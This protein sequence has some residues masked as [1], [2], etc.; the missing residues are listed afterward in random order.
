M[1]DRDSKIREMK[2]SLEWNFVKSSQMLKSIKLVSKISWLPNFEN[3]TFLFNLEM[4][5]IVTSIYSINFT[6]H[7]IESL[8]YP[9]FFC[10]AFPVSVVNVMFCWS[11]ICS[12]NS[13]VFRIDII[14][15]ISKIDA[16]RFILNNSVSV[17][18]CKGNSTICDYYMTSF[19]TTL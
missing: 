2:I 10:I 19:L 13:N 4:D 8:L 7:W 14:L 9:F 3:Q 6:E 11:I 1:R 15:L 5:S 16:I 12:T 18:I 17:R